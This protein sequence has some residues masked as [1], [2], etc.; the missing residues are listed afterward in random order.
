VA[1]D[2]DAK[3]IEH[4][5]AKGDTASTIAAKYGVKVSE[6]LAWNNLT[7]KSIIREGDVHVV[8]VKSDKP[9]ADSEKTPPKAKETKVAKA[10]SEAKPKA[11]PKADTK[12]D[13]KK[14]TK[15]AKA[16]AGKKDDARKDADTGKKATHVVSKGD[17]PSTI[18]FRY[19]VKL[20]DLYKWNNWGKKVVLQIGQKVTILKD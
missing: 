11:G 10:D 14:D 6:F 20:S 1:P 18:A 4:K 9:K 19:K 8:Y 3:K 15:A 5:V 7:T 16:D 13:A 2:E 12:S 17:S